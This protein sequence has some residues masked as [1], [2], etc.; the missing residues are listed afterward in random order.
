MAAHQEGGL[1]LSLCQISSDSYLLFMIDLL[2]FLIILSS[3]HFIHMLRGVGLLFNQLSQG[4]EY[5]SLILLIYSSLSWMYPYKERYMFLFLRNCSSY[6]KSFSFTQLCNGLDQ[7][8]S[9]SSRSSAIEISLSSWRTYFYK[10]LSLLLYCKRS[11]AFSLGW[12]L[13][14]YCPMS[15]FEER[16]K[17]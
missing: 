10:S 7:R 5:L 13:L 1:K 12:S 8:K 11:P 15:C 17:K 2:R 14:W 16:L 6:Q 3:L 9:L 4:F